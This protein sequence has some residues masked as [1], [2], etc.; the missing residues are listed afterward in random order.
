[1]VTGDRKAETSV[2]PADETSGGTPTGDDGGSHAATPPP[3]RRALRIVGLTVAWGFALALAAFVYGYAATDIPDPNQAF[4]AQTTLVYYQDGKHL[5]GRFATQ[6]RESVPLSDVPQHVQDAV[7]AAE[8]RTFYSNQG[9][10]PKGILR[11]VF[12]N[13]EGNPTQGA[14]TITQQ[15]VK[16]LYL[17]Q[18][19]TLSRKIR[20]AFLSLKIEHKLSKTQILEGY[21]NTIYFGRGAYG[22][23]AAAHAYFGTD[24]SHL[25]VRQGAVLAALINSPSDLDPAAGHD[26]RARLL[27]RYRYVLHGMAT[28]QLLPPGEADR[29]A[30]RLPRFPPVRTE[31]SFAGQR[32]YLM[33]LVKQQLE[34]DGFTD[35]EID[36]GGLRVTTTFTRQAMTAA[37]TAVRRHRPGGLKRLHVAVASVDPRTGALR[38][39]YAGQDY[40]ESHGGIDWAAAGG[41][42]GSAFKPFA[43]AAGLEDG[44]SL[45]ST[46]QGNSPYVFP[47]GRKV[48]NEGPNGGNDYGSR[49]SLLTATEQS[50]NT[51]YMD[52]TMSMH[53]GPAKILHSAVD[54]GVPRHA[55]GLA[56]QTGIALGSATVSPIDMANA[57]GTI[58]DGGMAKPWYVVTKVASPG[59]RTLFR[60]RT[61]AHR[62]V[63][64]DVDRDVSYALQQVV[65]H[66]TGRNAL[67]LG[68]PAA[69]KTGTATD[70]HGNVSSSWFVGYTP[71]LST[72][73]MYVRG[74]GNDPLN[75]YLPSYFGADY[76]TRTWTAVMQQALRGLPVQSF[77]PPAWLS[78]TR[79]THR[80]TPPPPKQ[81]AGPTQT[82]PAPGPSTPRSS[83]PPPPPQPTSGP[84]PPPPP[85][86]APSPTDTCTA[87]VCVG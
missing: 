3:N 11:A 1:V 13:A 65:A 37:E 31:S 2:L 16:V 61:H 28:M 26:A 57:Y 49:I 27:D 30:E 35:S 81:P 80:P 23:Q 69:G 72:A 42:P 86:P 34:K 21:L 77:P 36:G 71:Q 12:S 25:D 45:K 8:D 9:I 29:A 6:N 7:I 63:P 70:A 41:A 64:G 22:V 85:S 40:L 62:A 75:G 73:V 84:P 46:F 55:P 32:G 54:M 82:T 18:E 47:N 17:S 56:P 10:D 14:S 43:L 5:I 78:P 50:V 74:D 44:F 58:A 20:E 33:A 68:R 39:L 67:A 87:I 59:G 76:P 51:A 52:L 19:R 53:D 79:D 48:T 83:A 38:G 66:G 15:Y 60:Q 24:V 4:R